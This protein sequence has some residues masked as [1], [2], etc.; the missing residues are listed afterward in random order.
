MKIY[1]E[2]EKL[3]V[4]NGVRRTSN[5]NKNCKLKGLKKRVV[6]KKDGRYLIYFK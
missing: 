1:K 3:K 5:N 2:M 4:K 6:I